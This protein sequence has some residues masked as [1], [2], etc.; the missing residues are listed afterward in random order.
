MLVLD[1]T[2]LVAKSKTKICSRLVATHTLFLCPLAA[3]CV[4]IEPELLAHACKIKK[5]G[6]SV[7]ECGGLPGQTI[8]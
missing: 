8:I 5:I 3:I 6:D 4:Q 7:H 1:C 2:V